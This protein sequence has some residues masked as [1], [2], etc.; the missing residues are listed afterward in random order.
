MIDW[1]GADAPMTKRLCKAVSTAHTGGYPHFWARVEA[2]YGR[3]KIT[4]HV[5]TGRMSWDISPMKYLVG[6]NLFGTNDLGRILLG[7]LT[8]I[9][10]RFGLTFAERDAAFYADH[11]VLLSRVDVNGCFL[12]G[13]QIKVV[14]TMDLLREHFLDHGHN[15]VVHEAPDGIETLYLGKNSSNSTSKFYNKYLEMQAKGK[16]SSL[17][18]YTELLSLAEKM[19]R[20]EV[21]ERASALKASGLENS[22]E[23][24]VGTARD[25]LKGA[26]RDLGLSSKLLAELPDNDVTDLS[27]ASRAKYSLWMAGNDLCKHYAKH[28]FNRDRKIFLGKGIDIARTHDHARDAVALSEMLSVDQLKM[29]WPKRFVS[30]GAVYC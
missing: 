3:F 2:P 21:T 12:V 27:A 23:W 9:Y 17:P 14:D 19:V 25:V 29:T 18:Y 30:L 13:S 16:S 5:E 10:N 4:V 8:L 15:I 28:T 26:L 7:I 24:T 22:K 6:H 11:G 1:I 20:F